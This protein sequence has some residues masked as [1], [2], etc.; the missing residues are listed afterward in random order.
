MSITTALIL[1]LSPF[2]FQQLPNLYQLRK[3]VLFFIVFQLPFIL[4]KLMVLTLSNLKILLRKHWS[5]KILK[6]QMETK[7]SLFLTIQMKI[8][9][10]MIEF[11]VKKVEK[12]K[13]VVMVN[14]NACFVPLS[15]VYAIGGVAHHISFVSS[16]LHSYL[17]SYSLCYI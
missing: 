11:I 3:M 9:P 4:Y 16:L 8:Y 14:L 5:F 17:P 13:Q 10:R 6:S 15:P 1:V 12:I 2:K 7:I